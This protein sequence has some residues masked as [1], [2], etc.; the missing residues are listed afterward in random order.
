[1]FFFT[2][3]VQIQNETVK[4]LEEKNFQLQEKVEE[5]EVREFCFTIF[6]FFWFLIFNLK[7]GFLADYGLFWVGEDKSGS[8]DE[9]EKISANN[10]GKISIYLNCVWFENLLYE[11]IET[12]LY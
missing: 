2:A 3:N 1:M 12:Y 11:N 8:E 7:K 5:M 4:E 10:N 9:K 6:R